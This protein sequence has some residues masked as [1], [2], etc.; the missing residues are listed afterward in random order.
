MRNTLHFIRSSLQE[1]Y[2]P[3][4]I[5][6]LIRLIFEDLCKFTTVQLLLCKDTTLSPEI[7]QKTESIVERLKRHEPIQYI[8]G[9]T[10]FCGKR[11]TVGK[12]VLIPRPE[13]GEMVRQIVK[14]QN[15]SPL[16]IADYCT[17]SGCIAIALAAAFPEATI[18]GW[19]ISETALGYARRNAAGNNVSIQFGRLDVLS[20]KPSGKPTYDIIVSN[21]PYV[22]EKE[23]KDM[24]YNVLEYE[25][26]AALF[27]PDNNPL[28][29]YKAI[30]AIAKSELL[31]GGTLYFE[32]NSNMGDACKEMLHE[33]NFEKIT[34]Y[35]DFSG[36]NRVIKAV[37]PH[38][39]P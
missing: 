1:L 39:K 30:S 2:P 15:R 12:G 35:K 20:Y 18:E 27:V 29:F 8:L 22:L 16:H 24:E 21:P 9:H 26:E 10:D 23:R 3:G 38:V 13:T 28:L 14:D 7:R 25:P 5:E 11:I 19:D 34:I 17:G 36:L 37:K 33:A 4:E 6:S 32:I 31:P